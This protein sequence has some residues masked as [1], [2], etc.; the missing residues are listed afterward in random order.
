MQFDLL[1]DQAL[2]LALELRKLL[3]VLF[4]GLKEEGFVARVV[5]GLEGEIVL[6]ELL[7]CDN[8]VL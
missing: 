6:E 2:Y 4:R 7:L 1:F 3:Q 5:V 8:V